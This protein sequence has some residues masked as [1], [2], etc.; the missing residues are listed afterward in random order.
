[1]L[2]AIWAVSLGLF[3]V[4]ILAM[5]VLLCLRFIKQ[6]QD[7]RDQVLSAQLKK[8]IV[9]WLHTPDADV[10][11]LQQAAKANPRQM[12]RLLTHMASLLEGQEHARLV[13]L[14]KDLG[15]QA[16]MLTEL[17]RG[18]SG[19]RIKSA[20]ALAFF[21]TDEVAEALTASLTA[22]NP[23]LRLAA[24]R[25]L[26]HQQRQVPASALRDMHWE[27]SALV[28]GLFKQLALHQTDDLLALVR[29][30]SVLPER[31]VS[32]LSAL[33]N[34][35]DLTLLPIFIEMT[36]D[37]LAPLREV[38]V[39]GLGTLGHPRA[40]EAIERLLD[41]EQYRVR[42]AAVR[43]VGQ[44]QLEALYDHA[45]KLLADDSWWVRFAAA[46]ALAGCGEKGLSVLRRVQ[47]SGALEASDMASMALLEYT[48]G[49]E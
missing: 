8:A 21:N 2:Y 37:A 22:S 31:R 42:A 10:S 40:K 48:R 30:T 5:V 16:Y 11:V 41:D 19:Q 46:E 13:G 44:I 4:S 34:T 18:R 27:D 1:M 43:A 35:G 39:Q 14:C 6:R 32:A 17:F 15:L 33:A 28:D 9:I 45:A 36:S 26:A 20:E 25:S 24:A 23:E 47:A 12:V 29:D 38:A 3:L 7:K 49:V